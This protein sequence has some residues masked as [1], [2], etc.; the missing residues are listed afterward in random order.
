MKGTSHETQT[1]P[2]FRKDFRVRNLLHAEKG[3]SQSQILEGTAVA[4]AHRLVSR[5][6]SLPGTPG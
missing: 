4:L 2:L 6:E 5:L 1:Y 3:R